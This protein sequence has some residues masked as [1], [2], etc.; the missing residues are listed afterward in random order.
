MAVGCPVVAHNHGRGRGLFF[1][2]GD[3]F[4][5]HRLFTNMELVT[6]TRRP[7]GSIFIDGDYNIDRAFVTL[8]E[9]RNDEVED[10]RMR[11]A[12]K[13]GENNTFA[14]WWDFFSPHHPLIEKAKSMRAEAPKRITKEGTLNPLRTHGMIA[15]WL[16]VNYVLHDVYKIMVNYALTQTDLF[17]FEPPLNDIRISTLPHWDKDCLFS[18]AVA[19]SI[20][21]SRKMVGL[22]YR[23]DQLITPERQKRWRKRRR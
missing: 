19:K 6:V 13:Q 21:F 14:A 12:F 11:K 22:A 20:T 9:G 3:Y 8:Y 1:I 2:T 18:F 17:K 10:I 4:S 5:P 16:R 15:A 23:Y 7:N